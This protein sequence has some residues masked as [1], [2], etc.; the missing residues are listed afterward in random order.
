MTESWMKPIIL[1]QV[2]TSTW[3]GWTLTRLAWS[4]WYSLYWLDIN[5]WTSGYYYGSRCTWWPLDGE[6]LWPDSP[7]SP[8]VTLVLL[9]ALV[10]CSVTAATLLLVSALARFLLVTTLLGWENN[11]FRNNPSSPS[12]ATSLRVLCCICNCCDS[13]CHLYCHLET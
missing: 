10:S 5:G 4:C 7:T 3:S 12:T 6:L 1:Y 2:V 8:L 9:T 11:I 13:N